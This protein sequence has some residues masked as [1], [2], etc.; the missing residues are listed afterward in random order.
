MAAIRYIEGAFPQ[1]F[2][3]RPQVIAEFIKDANQYTTND[4]ISR[5]STTSIPAPEPDLTSSNIFLYI[6]IAGSWPG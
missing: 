3:L 6:C 5:Q 2:R 4:Y 1:V